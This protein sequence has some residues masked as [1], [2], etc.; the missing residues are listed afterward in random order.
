MAVPNLK[1]ADP[2]P[3]AESLDLTEF[4]APPGDVPPHVL[5]RMLI[6]RLGTSSG[7]VFPRQPSYAQFADRLVERASRIGGVMSFAVAFISVLVWLL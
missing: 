4:A 2:A 5:Q 7:V 6:E 1:Q 3:E